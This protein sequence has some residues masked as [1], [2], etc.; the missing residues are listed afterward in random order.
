MN[1]TQSIEIPELLENHKVVFVINQGSYYNQE[2]YISNVNLT[3]KGK[4]KHITLW[5]SYNS[6]SQNIKTE[7]IKNTFKLTNNELEVLL[8]K[9]KQAYIQ[10]EVERLNKLSLLIDR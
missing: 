6:S 5:D 9:I 2:I 10:A 3:P 4:R 8:D 7:L 1:N